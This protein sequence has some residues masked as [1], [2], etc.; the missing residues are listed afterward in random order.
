MP[1]R[2]T[3]RERPGPTALNNAIRGLWARAHEEQRSLTS[4]EQR[5]YQALVTAWTK[6]MDSEQGLA[7]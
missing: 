7:A 6:A 4:D 3:H 2:P 5:I 1:Q